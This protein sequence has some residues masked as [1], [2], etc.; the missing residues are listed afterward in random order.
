[1]ALR[2]RLIAAGAVFSSETDAEVIAHLIAATTTATWPRRAAAL[3]E[4]EGHFAFVAMSLDEPDVLVGRAASARWSSAR[5]RRAVHRLGRAGLPRPHALGAATSRTA[6][7]SCCAPARSRSAT[8]PARSSSARSSRSTGTRRPPR[9]AATRR[10]CS[11][12]STSRPTPRRDDQRPHARGDGVDLD[13]PGAFDESLL[14]GVKRVVI[15]ACGTAY[16]AGLIGRYAIEEW[17]RLPV[18]VDVASEY[19]YRNPLVGPGD[20]VI[21][22]SQ[23]G[24]TPTRSPRCASR[25]A[26]SARARADQ[27][28]GLAGHARRRRRALHARRARDRRRGDEDVRLPARGRVPAR[29]APRRAARH[30]RRRGSPS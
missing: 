19:R 12:R 9:R 24:E 6:R 18:E 27:R 7:S 1:M 21:G 2:E 13:E 5:R 26:R 30:A 11:R 22:I 23:S 4:L 15:V 29:A 17:A 25:A 10:S 28:D 14:D 16:H 20:L 3:R 8:P